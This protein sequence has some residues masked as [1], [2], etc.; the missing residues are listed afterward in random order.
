MWRS[1]GNRSIQQPQNILRLEITGIE[2]QGRLGVSAR[3]FRL[4]QL[5]N[6]AG[7]ASTR[8]VRTRAPP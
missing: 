1:R 6:E 4:A 3:G 7:R 2:P 5:E 8:P